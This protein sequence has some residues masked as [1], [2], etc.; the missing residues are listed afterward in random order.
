MD[1]IT[2]LIFAQPFRNN[3]VMNTGM[4]KIGWAKA[5]ATTKEGP[6]DLPGLQGFTLPLIPQQAR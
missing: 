5:F 6:A 1:Y 4:H 3:S 2:F